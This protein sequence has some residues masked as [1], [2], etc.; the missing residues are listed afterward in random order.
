[1]SVGATT[2]LTAALAA[3]GLAGFSLASSILSR[4]F[5]P[6][7]MARAGAWVGLPAFAAVLGAA[8]SQSI[9]LFGAGVLLIGFGAGLF[10]HGTLTLTMNRAPKE[11]AG[12]AL[13]AWGAVQATAAGAA[14]ALGGIGRDLV[15]A[16]ARG[17]VFGQ[18]LNSPAT[19]YA[20]IYGLEIVLLVAT[21]I[22]MGKLIADRARSA[23]TANAV[24]RSAP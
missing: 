23:P 15:D 2:W 22:A 19:G 20:A 12:L 8:A 11:Q 21:V 18:A 7:R 1:M 16:L 3:G 14:V 10:G 4:G 9:E 5:D 24:F 17:K 13:G 6:A